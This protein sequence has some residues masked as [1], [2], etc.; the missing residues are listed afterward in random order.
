MEAHEQLVACVG[1]E[2][3]DQVE[4]VDH[5]YEQEMVIGIGA[6]SVQIGDVGVMDIRACNAE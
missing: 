5:E 2:G 1:H 3:L 4:E 6:V